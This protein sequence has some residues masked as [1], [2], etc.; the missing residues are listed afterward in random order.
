LR[1]YVPPCEAKR[2][3]Y[4]KL[5]IVL[6]YSCMTL[7]ITEIWVN[8]RNVLSFYTSFLWISLR[9]NQGHFKGWGLEGNASAAPRVC[10]C[11]RPLIF[12][13][14]WLARRSSPGSSRPG[15]ILFWMWLN[16][17]ICPVMKDIVANVA[18]TE[19]MDKRPGYPYRKLYHYVTVYLSWH[20]NLMLCLL[21][22]PHTANRSTGPT[23]HISQC[24]SHAPE[25]N[26]LIE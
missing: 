2:I 23:F 14:Y 12:A 20:A 5:S 18:F 10:A 16:Y 19:V 17:S 11:S 13:A 6:W 21:S 24:T 25:D 4:I 7:C 8:W 26:D 22:T 3:S 15:S 9:G 1:E